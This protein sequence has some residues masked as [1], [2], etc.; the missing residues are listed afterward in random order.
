[1]DEQLQ[2]LIS[3]VSEL[4]TDSNIPRNVKAKLNQISKELKKMDQA[5]MSLTIN[6]LLSDLDDISSDANL[7]SFTR[8]QIWSITSMLECL[9]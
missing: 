1:M 7:D 8:Q 6:K 9:N 3:Y 4:E 2:E 5:T